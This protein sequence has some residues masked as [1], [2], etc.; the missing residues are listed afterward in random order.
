MKGIEIFVIGNLSKYTG[1]SLALLDN[2]YLT[3]ED[4]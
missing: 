2:V 3:I 1:L 4:K